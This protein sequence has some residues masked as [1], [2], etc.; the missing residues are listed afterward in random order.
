MEKPVPFTPEDMARRKRRAIVMA[1]ILVAVAVLFFVS[2]LV[3]LGGSIAD[4]AV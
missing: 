3:R 1:L 2:T 4:R